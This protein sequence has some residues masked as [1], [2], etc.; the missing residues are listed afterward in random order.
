MKIPFNMTA[1]RLKLGEGEEIEQTHEGMRKKGIFG[2][3]FGAL[4][5]TNQ[6]VA[7][8]KAIMKSGVISAAMNAKGAKPMVA[9]NRSEITGAEKLQIKKQ[10]ALVVTAGANAEKFVMEEAAIDALVPLL[11]RAG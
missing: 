10:M 7:F 11:S 4:H 3:R 1:P 8:V 6:R 9:F 2:N 5:V